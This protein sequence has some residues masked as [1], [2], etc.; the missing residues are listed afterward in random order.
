[1]KENNKPWLVVGIIIVIVLILGY[2][3]FSSKSVE[4]KVDQQSEKV[5]E[6]LTIE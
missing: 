6:D 2:W 4:R 5:I 3:V 1:M